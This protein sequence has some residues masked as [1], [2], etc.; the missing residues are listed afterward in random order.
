MTENETHKP[1][2]VRYLCSVKLMTAMGAFI[3]IFDIETAD[4]PPPAVSSPAYS[5][6][7]RVQE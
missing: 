4:R 1:G 2:S 6:D 3:G 7:Q 5:P